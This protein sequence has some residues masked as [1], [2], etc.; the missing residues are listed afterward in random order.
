[1]GQPLA[2]PPFHAARRDQ[3]QLLGE[4]SGSGVGEQRTE[5]VGEQVGALSTVEVQCHQWPR[6][7]VLN[8]PRTTQSSPTAAAEARTTCPRPQLT[9]PHR[10]LRL[11]PV[12]RREGILA[13]I[14]EDAS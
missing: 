3:H 13:R 9:D 5:A 11:R 4:G 14:D 8:C 7:N 6:A 10:P 2:Q 1:M 12:D